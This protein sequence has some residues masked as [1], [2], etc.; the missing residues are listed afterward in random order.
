SDLL[1][2]VGTRC[3]SGARLI[4]PVQVGGEAPDDVE[5]AAV[6][7]AVERASAVSRLLALDGLDVRIETPF[8]DLSDR[9]LCELALDLDLAVT[10]L[11]WWTDHSPEG[12][13]L[14]AR[15]KEVF[16]AC[17]CPVQETR[18]GP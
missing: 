15:W 14:D 13:A 3:G 7:D 17:G 12:R 4:W 18:T 11:W 8:V 5:V 16:D 1:L 6:A 2:Q 10:G 9:Q